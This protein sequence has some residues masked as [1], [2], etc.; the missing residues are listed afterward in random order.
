LEWVCLG[1]S[2][3]LELWTSA[4]LWEK[5]QEEDN[6]KEPWGERVVAQRNDADV[7]QIHGCAEEKEVEEIVEG[8]M[9]LARVLSKALLDSSA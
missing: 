7:H 2:L 1:L 4:S 9:S 5:P 3:D 8:Q 6:P